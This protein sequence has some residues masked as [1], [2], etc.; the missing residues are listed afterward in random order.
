MK[1]ESLQF[2]VNKQLIHNQ[3]YLICTYNQNTQQLLN[4]FKTIFGNLTKLNNSLRVDIA[5]NLVSNRTW[6]QDSSVTVEGQMDKD[7]LP[8]IQK[9]LKEISPGFLDSPLMAIM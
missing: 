3:L 2:V 6:L 1:L 9:A 5:N 4:K 8:A 7:T